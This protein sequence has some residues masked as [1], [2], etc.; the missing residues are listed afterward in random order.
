MHNLNMPP[1]ALSKLLITHFSPMLIRHGK[2][3][4]VWRELMLANHYPAG[5]NTPKNWRTSYDI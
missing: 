3:R 5:F 1:T 2:S 4:L